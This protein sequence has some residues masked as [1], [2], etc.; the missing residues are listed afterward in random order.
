MSVLNNAQA[1]YV[2]EG[3]AAN[4]INTVVFRHDPLVSFRDEQY[5]AFYD[6]QSNLVLAKR[7]LGSNNWQT[8]VSPFKGKTLDA[9]NSISITV[10]GD[11]Y[12]HVSWDHHNNVLRYCR[13]VKPGSLELTEKM[14]MTGKKEEHV[15]YPE[16][17]KMPDGNLLFLYRDGSSG[18]G[19][20]MLNRYDLKERQ[21]MQLQDG[22]IDGEGQRNAYWQMAIDDNGTI[23]LSWVWRESGDVASNHDLC[24][25]RSTD[26]GKTWE[27]TTG[28]KYTLPVRAASAEY[29]YNIP[30]NSELINQTSMCADASGRPFIATFWRAQGTTVPQ[31][32]LVYHD[33]KQWNK[34]QVSNR[35]SAFTL[36]GGGTKR[37]P[38][39]RPQIMMRRNGARE[40]ALMVYRDEERGDKVSVLTCADFP[41]GK[42]LENDLTAVS[43]GQWEPGYDR[44][45]WKL[46]GLLHLF[47]QKC[48]QGDG[49]GV[50]KGPPQPVMVLEWNPNNR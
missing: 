49:E 29:A 43:V 12:L 9:H 16:F 34:I 42:W 18:N 7:K 40:L 46:K 27:K 25:A 14:P 1:V 41:T 36:S 50:K 11:G 5:T 35:K 17:Y 22:F 24:Y 37:I 48:E 45:L 6:Q 38:I 44:E 39:A 31:Y 32:Q 19:N 2:A 28:E 20:L 47:V 21:W 10:D 8:R 3:W 15:T 23:H 4:S 30:E 26:G 33:G 13:S